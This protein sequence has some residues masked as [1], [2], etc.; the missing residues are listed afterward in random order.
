[1]VVQLQTKIKPIQTG[2]EPK[3]IVILWELKPAK[4]WVKVSSAMRLPQCSCSIKC[5][6]KDIMSALKT[7]PERSLFLL[8]ALE[9]SRQICSI[10]LN[11]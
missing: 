6:F 11:Q 4:G 5:L 3:F 10:V 2:T 9:I 1:M 7:F 8:V